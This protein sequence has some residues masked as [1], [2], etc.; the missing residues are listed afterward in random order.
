MG[1]RLTDRL[2]TFARRQRLETQSLNLNEFVLGLIELLRRTIGAPID[3]STSLAPDLWPTMADPGQVESAVLNLVLNARDAMPSGGRLVIETFNATVDAGDEVSDAGMAAGDYVVLSVA[4]TGHGMPPEVRARAFEPF[5]TTKG[6]GKGSGLGLATIYGFARQSGGNVTIY[7][8]AGKG[9]TVNLYLPRAGRKTEEEAPAVK[10]DVDAGRGETVLIVED[11]DRVRRLTATRLKELGYRVLEANHGAA[12]LA[13]LAETPGVEIVFSDLV[14][15][16]GMSGFD[17][18][19][20]VRESHPQVHVILTSGYS[21]ELMNQADI[22]QLDLQVL[23][24]PYRQA[25]LACAFRA[26]LSRPEPDRTG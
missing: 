9:T 18:A 1:A 6:A 10:P 4:D 25:Q 16:G 12:A 22:A 19:R 13:V 8:E 14:M 2:L 24:K 17:L 7:S 3:L 20:R 11:D 15:P 26:A 5:F 23:R 21:A